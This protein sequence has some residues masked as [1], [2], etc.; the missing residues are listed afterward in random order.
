[1]Y[2]AKWLYPDLLPDLDP[3]EVFR[4]WLEDFQGFRNVGGHFCRPGTNGGRG[5]LPPSCWGVAGE[6]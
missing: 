5:G 1:M 4:A 2:I 6:C 3:D